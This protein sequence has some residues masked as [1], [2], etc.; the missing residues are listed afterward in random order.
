MAATQDA[1][2]THAVRQIVVGMPRNMHGSYGPQAAKTER[3]MHRLGQA[4]H[5]PCIPWDER[6]TTQQAERFLITANLRRDKRKTVRDKIAAQ[7][8]LQNYLDAQRTSTPPA[9]HTDG[10]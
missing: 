4:C 2:R 6:L 5:L 10:S 1:F 8:I 7:L 3:F 9:G